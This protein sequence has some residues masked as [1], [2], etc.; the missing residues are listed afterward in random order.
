M[1][2]LNIENAKQ[3]FFTDK[4]H[5][6]NFR[7][8]WAEA[9]N[10]PKNKS[11]KTQNPWIT[12]THVLLFCLLTEKSALKAFTP[13]TNKNKLLNGTNPFYGLASAYASLKRNLANAKDYQTYMSNAANNIPLDKWSK[14]KGITDNE[15]WLDR[16]KTRK[17]YLDQFLAPFNGTVTIGMLY[18]LSTQVIFEQ[19]TIFD[20]TKQDKVKHTALTAPITHQM[21]WE[22][23]TE[24]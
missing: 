17:E 22:M 19:T 5:Y 18:Y 16:A 3:I 10:S 1:K 15:V 20:Y 13:V 24:G 21:L 7:K 14:R 4:Q 12:S 8:A 23:Y 11:T 2:N 9:V 6:L